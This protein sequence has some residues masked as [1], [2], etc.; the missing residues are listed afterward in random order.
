MRAAIPRNLRT[1]EWAVPADAL[2]A[3]QAGRGRE[4]RDPSNRR[5]IGAAGPAGGAGQDEGDQR[6][7][8]RGG[9]ARL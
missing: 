4:R 5:R 7:L 3:E 2:K 1:A 6:S 9:Q 8:A